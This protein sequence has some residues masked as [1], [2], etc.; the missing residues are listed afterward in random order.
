MTAPRTLALVMISNFGR[1]DGGRETWAYQFLPR[2]L[3]RDPGLHLDI[4]GLRADDEPDNLPGLMAAFAEQDR[5]RVTCKFHRAKRGAIPLSLKMLG[6]MF[7]EGNPPARK[8][9]DLVLSVGSFVDLLCALAARPFSKSPKAL[10]L[11]TIYLDEKAHRIPNWLRPL[12]RSVETAVLRRADLLIA[13]GDDTAANYR[14]RGFQVE[15]IK[16]AVDLDRWKMPP[17]QLEEPIQVA[18]IGRLAAVKGAAE[19][20]DL[21]KHL[22]QSG[23][24]SRF[25]FHVVGEGEFA[26][27]ARA[28]QAGGNLTFHGPVRNEDLPGLMRA[29]DVCVAL[30]FVGLGENGRGGG[31]GVSN[32]VLEQM[33]AGR[34]MLCWDNIAYGQ[35]LDDQSAY[36]AAQGSISAL[37]GQLQEI[38]ANPDDALRRAAEAAR[39]A[40]HYSFDGHIERF[41][42]AVKRWL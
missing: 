16:N 33:A 21:A 18:F 26:D 14:S 25:H 17:P 4:R 39:Q 1:S 3:S 42:G 28:A 38:A 32:A 27:S 2:L 5:S 41:V 6:A 20:L 23:E 9:P 7:R 37:A 8:E 13:N 11:R 19:F 34:V 22:A 29:I 30:G 31:S 35:V 40:Q 24:K 36:F 15:V 12:L 10:W